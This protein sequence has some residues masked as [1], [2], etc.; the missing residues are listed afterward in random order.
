MAT[1]MHKATAAAWCM[2]CF[3]STSD[4]VMGDHTTYASLNKPRC[5]AQSAQ[6]S[7]WADASISV[8]LNT[9]CCV[10]QLLICA[11]TT[12]NDDQGPLGH[13]GIQ[14]YKCVCV[15][16]WSCDAYCA[17]CQLRAL[18]GANQVF[19]HSDIQVCRHSWTHLVCAIQI[20]R[21]RHATGACYHVPQMGIHVFRYLGMQVM[22]RGMLLLS[23][24]VTRTAPQRMSY[25]R[26]LIDA[27][28]QVFWH[29]GIQVCKHSQAHADGPWAT[30]CCTRAKAVAC[31]TA[32]CS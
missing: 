26:A 31:G 19:W 1:V 23:L 22:G 30:S 3:S 32:C 21:A 6:N 16:V 8:H 20:V 15:V 5:V 7:F 12:P 13:S 10:Q 4:F 2:L 9:L 28:V 14:V 24:P 29:S 25:V 17:S 27:A 11:S 18:L